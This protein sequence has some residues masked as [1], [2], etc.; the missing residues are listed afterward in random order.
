MLYLLEI[1]ATCILMDSQAH[2]YTRICEENA[3]K[4]PYTIE[5]N[6]KDVHGYITTPPFPSL[7]WRDRT[8]RVLQSGH[9]EEIWKGGL[10]SR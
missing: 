5:K 1:C 7:V 6:T 4:T 10:Q 3:Q 9:C 8:Y 2:M